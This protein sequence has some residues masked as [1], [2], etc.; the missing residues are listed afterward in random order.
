MAPRTP[1]EAVISSPVLRYSYPTDIFNPNNSL[2]G[3]PYPYIMFTSVDPVANG[4]TI[5][6]NLTLY[7]PPT[8]KVRYQAQY[9][10]LSLDWEKF[11]AF[12]K[13][14]AFG[15]N[16]MD[17]AIRAGTNILGSQ[18]TGEY[19]LA[20]RQTV[21][22]HMALLF[23]GIGFRE[24]Q[25]DFQLMA[26]NPQESQQIY[27]IIRQ[28]KLGMHPEIKDVAERWWGYPDNW[29]IVVGANGSANNQFLFKIGTCV[30]QGMEVDYAG[31]G[32]PS[33]FESTGAPVDVRMTLNFK[34]T[35]VLTKDLVD[36]GF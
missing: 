1:Q 15:Q 32:V 20:R 21:N 31:S 14:F 22:P 30:L 12:A 10:E 6:S 26:K 2:L 27:N 5:K 13:D 28:F 19:E 29:N 34:E 35:A 9:E 8:V 25:F 16:Q 7:L 4:G 24:F 33:F 36:K 18:L 23:K 17:S 3:N 11:K